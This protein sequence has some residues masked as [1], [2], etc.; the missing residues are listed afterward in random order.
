MY[1]KSD[2]LLLGLPASVRESIQ[3]ISD[4]TSIDSDSDNGGVHSSGAFQNSMADV[5]TQMF[6]NL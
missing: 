5:S 4:S 2:C 1:F 3:R 6:V